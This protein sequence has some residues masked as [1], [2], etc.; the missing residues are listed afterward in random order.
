MIEFYH[1]V[2]VFEEALKLDDAS[3]Q[4]QYGAQKP[5]LDGSN[6]VINCRSGIRSLTALKIARSL[7]YHR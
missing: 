5:E 3:F 2:D 4:D 1:S 7:G 6:V